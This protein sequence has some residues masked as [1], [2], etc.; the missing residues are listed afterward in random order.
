MDIKML[1]SDEEIFVC[2]KPVGMLSEETPDRSDPQSLADILSAQNGGYIGV[3]HRLDRGVG[4]V[5]VYA[6]TKKAAARLSAAVQDHT[7]QK[8]YLATVHGTPEKSD[9][10][11]VDLLYHDRAKNKTFVVTRERRGVKQAIL[12]YETLQTEETAHGTVSL[13]KIRLHTGRTHQIRAQFASRRHPLVGDRKYGST[14][15]GDIALFCHSLTLPHPKTG[16]PMTFTEDAPF[17]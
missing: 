3:V 1:Y 8:T 7:F 10:T 9:D 14:A 12:D 17:R 15:H 4:G 13:L 5:M 16:V 2:V 6:R 11:L